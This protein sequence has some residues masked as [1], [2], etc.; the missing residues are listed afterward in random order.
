VNADHFQSHT[1]SLVLAWIVFVPGLI[2]AA[3]KGLNL[4]FNEIFNE[5]NTGVSRWFTLWFVACFVVLSPLR[6]ILLQLT[7]AMAFPF[8]SVRAFLST[9]LLALY[10][11]IVF[12][13]MHA[14]G[15]ALPCYAVFRMAIEKHGRTN[16][17][18]IWNTA[19][20]TPFV[21]LAATYVFAS[22]LPIA[23]KS[24]HW[25]DADDVIRAT[26]GPACLVYRYVSTWAQVYE[27]PSYAERVKQDDKAALRMHVATVYLSGR[28]EGKFLYFAYPDIY[29]SI[30]RTGAPKP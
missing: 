30:L 19:V 22:L 13:L 17:R 2:G 15:V 23:A 8:Q 7:I 4:V 3:L 26:N 6:Y 12:G 11:P 16:W 20:V 21:F 25:L 27:M 5:E 9:F 28:Q 18:R 10:V 29:N 24:V 1:L 14:L